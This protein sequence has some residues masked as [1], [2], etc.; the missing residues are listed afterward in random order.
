MVLQLPRP[1]T[2]DPEPDHDE[3]VR[4]QFARQLAAMLDQHGQDYAALLVRA[5]RTDGL[6][7]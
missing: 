5:E 2:A 3:L 7:P 1:D 6:W 4:R